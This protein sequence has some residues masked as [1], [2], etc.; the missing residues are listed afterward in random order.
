MAFPICK[1]NQLSTL[2]GGL[3]LSLP[4]H[5]LSVCSLYRLGPGG[6]YGAFLTLSSMGNGD[7]GP[8][9]VTDSSPMSIT[10]QP[11]GKG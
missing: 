7:Q 8:A 6:E 9:A 3:S 10:I 1:G 2:S 4:A 11:K 5:S